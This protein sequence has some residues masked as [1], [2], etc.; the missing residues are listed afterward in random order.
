MKYERKK[1]DDEKQAEILYR[2][3]AGL[4]VSKEEIAWYRTRK[5]LT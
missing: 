5:A 1:S 3:D 2:W 4:P